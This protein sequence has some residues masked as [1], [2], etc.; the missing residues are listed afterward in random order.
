MR[1]LFA[2]F[3][4]LAVC[5]AFAQGADPLRSSECAAAREVLD[6]ATSAA[7]ARQAGAATRLAHARKQAIHACLGREDAERKRGGAPD[8]SVV[9]APPVMAPS[10]AVTLAATPA[11]APP[12]P[13]ARPSAITTCDPGGCW[14]SEGRR[15]NGV[16]PLLVGPQGAC[17]VQA[18]VVHCP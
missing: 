18:G 12:V 5:A 14:D 17:S 10:R 7:V 15:L 6:E 13:I 2:L 9:V 4:S 16:G 11:P 1:P 3:T 8:R